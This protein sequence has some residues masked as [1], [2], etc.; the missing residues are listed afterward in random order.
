MSEIE[1]ND[2]NS[3]VEEAANEG[4]KEFRMAV[5]TILSAIASDK[6]LKASMILKGGILLAIR[7]NSHR[8]TKDMDFSTERKLGGEITEDGV[9]ESLDSSLAQMIEVLDYDLDCRVQSSKLQPKDPKSTY[10]SITLKIG[11][12]FKGT[13]KHKR[14]LILKSPDAIS[15]DYSL[16]EATP[17]VE[18]LKLD[19]EDGVLV[20]TLTDLIAEKYRSLLQQVPRKR[21]RRQDV[22]DLDLLIG[23]LNNVDDVEK[24]NILNC[25]ISKSK[26]RDIYPDVNSFDD[27]ELKSR[28]QEHYQTLEDEVEGELPNFDELFLKVAAFYK[29]L[30]WE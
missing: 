5:H 30:P 15:I 27:P 22:Y 25:L 28:A 24:Y 2:I 10:P 7:Y 17:N 21:T 14:L 8:Y 13:P 4:N 19:L 1:E 12:A 16:N 9:R 23:K 18:D 3:W 6:N 29:S 11:Y 26:A 20:Y